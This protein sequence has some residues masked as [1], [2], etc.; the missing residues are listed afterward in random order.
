M[1][2]F[3]SAKDAKKWEKTKKNTKKAIKNG[4]LLKP[5]KSKRPKKDRKAKLLKKAKY[6]KKTEKPKK[7][8]KGPSIPKKTK[9]Q[10]PKM[11]KSHRRGKCQE[12]KKPKETKI[13]QD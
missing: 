11:Q 7:N 3:G 4:K 10:V 2:N 5:K 1:T 6:P 9:N 13:S 12:F 8:L